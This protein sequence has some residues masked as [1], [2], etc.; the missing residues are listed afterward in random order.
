MFTPK[1]PSA[2]DKASSHSGAATVTTGLDSASRPRSLL[3]KNE[4]PGASLLGDEA[5]IRI[6]EQGAVIRGPPAT[7]AC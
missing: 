7:A 3:G 6:D 2:S 5:N 4:F 1:F